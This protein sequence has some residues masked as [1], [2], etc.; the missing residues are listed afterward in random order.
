MSTAGQDGA[1]GLCFF[2]LF[3][4]FRLKKTKTMVQYH[5]LYITKE[6]EHGTFL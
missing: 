2:R 5:Y 1:A 6:T 3:V 4:M